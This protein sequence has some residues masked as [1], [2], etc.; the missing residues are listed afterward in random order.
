MD[1]E[2]IPKRNK[3]FQAFD[4][5]SVQYSF[6]INDENAYKSNFGGIA[7]ILYFL[8][9]IFYFGVSFSHFWNGRNYSINYSVTSNKSS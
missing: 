5:F 4:Y 1:N 7:F 9:S 3:F 6:R 2:T 8:F